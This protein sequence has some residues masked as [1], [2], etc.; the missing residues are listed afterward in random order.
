[1]QYSKANFFLKFSFYQISK[2]VRNAVRVQIDPTIKVGINARCQHLNS[3]RLLRD[4]IELAGP[5][6][7]VPQEP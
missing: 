1:M 2:F 6:G 7:T 3:W 5:F 4:K